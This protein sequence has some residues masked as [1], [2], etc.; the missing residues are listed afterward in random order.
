MEWCQPVMV[1]SELSCRFKCQSIFLANLWLKMRSGHLLS[2]LFRSHKEG[3]QGQSKDMLET[4]LG[5]FRSTSVFP[6]KN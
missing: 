3:V 6:Q 2:E 1:K 4:S 5:C